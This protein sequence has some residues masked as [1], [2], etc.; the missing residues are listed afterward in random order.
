LRGG[1]PS[2]KGTRALRRV[3]SAK[4]AWDREHGEADPDDY[5]RTI[6]PKLATVPLRDLMHVT[7]MSK[8][9]CSRIQRGLKVPH[10]RHWEALSAVSAK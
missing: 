2:W 6:L 9:T 4:R 10:P 3:F 8:T 1:D 5:R 7:G